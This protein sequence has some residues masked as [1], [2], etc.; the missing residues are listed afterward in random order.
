MATCPYTQHIYYYSIINN[1]TLVH[2]TCLC[3]CNMDTSD[4]TLDIFDYDFDLAPRN[5]APTQAM[6]DDIILT[7]T[8]IAVYDIN[9]PKENK[10]FEV[11]ADGILEESVDDDNIILNILDD[12]TDYVGHIMIHENPESPD[13]T[14]PESTD[15]NSDN[16]SITNDISED[17][18]DECGDAS[19]DCNEY[20]GIIQNFD[21]PDGLF[22]S[23]LPIYESN[24]TSEDDI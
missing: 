13:P 22:L 15:Y 2:S 16:E 18:S 17:S 9:N 20:V 3:N 19:S 1:A 10:E 6:D 5:K 7:P 12:S 23:D 4:C 8:E 21:E 24:E 11:S 14:S